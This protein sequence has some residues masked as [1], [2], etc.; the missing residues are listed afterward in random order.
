MAQVRVTSF[1]ASWETVGSFLRCQVPLPTVTFTPSRSILVERCE[2]CAAPVLASH[3]EYVDRNFVSDLNRS[4]G[5]YTFKFFKQG[6][7]G[8]SL[9]A[10]L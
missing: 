10:P 3:K 5:I 6:Q 7:V 9:F 2:C 1:K 8:S 4:K